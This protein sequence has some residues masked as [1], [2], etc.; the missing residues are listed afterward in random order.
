MS[1]YY[2]KTYSNK[3]SKFVVFEEDDDGF[4]DVYHEDKICKNLISNVL[5]FLPR[6]N[7]VLPNMDERIK[8][9][10]R[11]LDERSDSYEEAGEIEAD[12]FNGFINIFEQ[13]IAKPLIKRW[14]KLRNKKI[15]KTLT[16]PLQEL[17]KEVVA[18]KL[19]YPDVQILT[20]YQIQIMNK[21]QKC[22]MCL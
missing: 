15:E 2:S 19:R 12:W 7:K 1:K 4:I 21:Y 14:N 11:L 9:S 6:T 8:V 16:T 22:C 10:K 3:L 5:S 20:Q 13:T 17:Y 18:M